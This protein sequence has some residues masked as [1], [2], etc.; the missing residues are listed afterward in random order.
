MLDDV[1]R[2]F[3]ISRS[4]AVLSGFSPGP[5]KPN[6]PAAD[7]VTA[8]SGPDMTRIGAPTMSGVVVHG[9]VRLS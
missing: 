8:S 1:I 2:F 7:I 6:P 9:Y 3:A 5:M 4:A